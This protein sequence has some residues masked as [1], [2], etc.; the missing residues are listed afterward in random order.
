ME[1]WPSSG[2]A[3]MNRGSP[4]LPD[5]LSRGHIL[6][7]VRCIVISHLKRAMRANSVIVNKGKGSV[8]E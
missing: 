8:Y 6:G 7:P 3:E 2:P 5:P 1:L 4:H